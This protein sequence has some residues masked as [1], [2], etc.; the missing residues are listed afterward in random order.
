[1]LQKRI[2]IW[3]VAALAVS[4]CTTMEGQIRSTGAMGQPDADYVGTASQIVQLDQQSGKLAAT[5]AADPRVVDISNQ[6][7]AQ[8]TVLSPQLQAAAKA[9]GIQT[10]VNPSGNTAAE[11][12]QLRSLKGPAFDHQYL[13]DELAAHQQAVAAFKKEDT[14]TKDGTMRTLVETA[15]PTV[16]NNLAK[17]QYLSNDINSSHG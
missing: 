5:Q 4:G 6:L 16:Q 13:A 11:I 3:I 2:P 7:A 14:S 15:L 1:M 10:P 12:D 8:A 9:E 17:L